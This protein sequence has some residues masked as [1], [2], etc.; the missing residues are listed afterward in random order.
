MEFL[1]HPITE[2][3]DLV[4]DSGDE[5]AG[6]QNSRVSASQVAPENSFS[7]FESDEDEDEKELDQKPLISPSTDIKGDF[8][9]ALE[10]GFDFDGV[11]A[12]SQRYE[13][14]VTPNPCLDIEGL[15]TVGIPLSERDARAIITAS[16]DGDTTT[17]TTGTWEIPAEKIHFA[18]PA[19][20]NWIQK[21][22][23]L[24]AFTALTAYA[25]ANPSFALKKLVIHETSSHTTHYKEPIDD[26][27][28]NTKIGDFIVILPATFEGAQLLLR[29]AGQIKSLNFAHQSGLS[30]SV[31]AA[32]SGVEHTLSGIASGYR[33]SLVYDMVQPITQAGYRP[34][35]PEMQGATQKLHNIMLSWKQDTSGTA[36]QFL[37]C[38]L[39]HKYAKTPNFSAKSLTGADALLVSHLYPLARQLKFRI[40]LAHI[41]V[42][43]SIPC[44]AED[45]GYG[46]YG[47][48]GY[49]RWGR[50]RYE[51]DDD[52]IDEAE[53]EERHGDRE[54]TLIVT[55]VVSLNGLPVGV[56]LDLAD[57]DLLN[58]SVT[59][60]DPDD[61][62]FERDDRT[63]ATR[64]KTYNRTVLVIWPKGSAKDL[65]VSVGDVYDYACNALKNSLT[66]SPTKKEKK[67][68]DQLVECCRTRRQEPKLRQ[69]VQV[70]RE[71]ADRWNDVQMLLRA[72]KACGVDKNS[73]LMGLEGFVSA[74]QAFGW[75]ALKD[76]YTDAMTNDESNA[77]RHALLARLTQ[78][79]VDEEDAEVSAWCKDQGDCI[80]RSLSKIDAAQIP[81][82]TDLGLARGGEFL[83]D[84][85][86]PQL[87]AQ[88]LDKTFWIPFIRQIQLRMADIPSTSATVVQGLIVQCV[89]ETVRTL[90]AFPTK[91]V[92][93]PYPYPGLAA[94][95][96]EKDSGATLEV[97]KLCIDTK[98]EALCGEIST[99][100]RD[101]A[102]RGTYS[103]QFPP[104]LYYTELSPAL[105]LY[106]QSVA[107]PNTLDIIFRP[108]FLD[109][110]TSLASTARVSPTGNPITPCP[111][112]DSHK[113]I[114]MSA[115]R[116]AGGISA[117]QQRLNATTL[118]GHD[119]TALQALVRSIVKEFPRQQLAPGATQAYDDLV[120]TL[121][122]TAIDT[123]DTSSL[124]P[125]LPT[126]TAYY[127][128][129]SRLSPSD[130]MIRLIQFCFEVGAQSQCQRLLL[131][132]VP[133]PASS[134]VVDHVS[135][136]LAPFL[137]VLQRYLVSQRLDLQTEPYKKFAAAVIKSFAE[138]VMAQKPSEV[139]PAAQL[140]AI[141]C[142]G[143]AEC[144]QLRAFLLSDKPTISF[145]RVQGIRTHLERQLNAI[146]W[147]GVTCETIRHGSP[148]TLKITK[149]ASMTALG[150]WNANSQT[151][152][153]LLG[154]L[155]DPATQ[156]RVLG[157]DHSWVHARIHGSP[158]VPLPL[159]NANQNLTAQKRTAPDVQPGF[160]AVSKKP[161]Q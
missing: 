122:R 66:V 53:F 73:E 51:Y 10:E 58:G 116:K 15:G 11:F 156:M 82:L 26:D 119:S 92:K 133:P 157:A 105:I 2:V 21:T 139:I 38:L 93:S 50:R 140:Q 77:R 90:P 124:I 74:Y 91:V 137:P 61:D 152:K 84:V 145:S 160:M 101:A 69:V 129:G 134:T 130:H 36:P 40:Y 155:G 29:H 48:G 43:E 70:L 131:R 64:I 88:K 86:F 39:Q 25:A 127:Y 83:R 121:V 118:K 17:N 13:I 19:W 123:F 7:D 33:L 72:V 27:E 18:N 120:I 85:I 62:E 24:A 16:F 109:V 1:P 49:G 114:M 153:T 41:T 9:A 35:L 54:E 150:L 102:S 6:I 154:A 34:V 47:Y 59:T 44:E 158:S 89:T 46:G 57:G 79:A 149:P 67:L 56:N 115:A 107:T 135:K 55:Q 3:I 141:G 71:S 12:F 95:R 52:D 75:D 110:I 5:G 103:S 80:L 108:F 159:A 99:K 68:V 125:P 14:G 87:H 132:F 63:T 111:L 113:L 65:G 142:Q 148:H 81:W 106:M 31:I 100:M 78:M 136:V 128:T 32:Y 143:C 117:L 161:R 30:T 138:K 97:I 28:S 23:G 104:W 94:D 126:H 96:E 8:G 20:D 147:L 60:D 22:T 144:P 37:A 42:T 98:N 45:Y 76:F 4:D 151:G 146:R 112:N